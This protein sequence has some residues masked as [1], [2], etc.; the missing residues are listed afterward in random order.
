MRRLH[1]TSIVI[2]SGS[3]LAAGMTLGAQDRYALRSP[4]GISFAELKGYEQWQL[5]APSHADHGTGCGTSPD[6]GCMKVILGNPTMI[7]AY[8]DGVPANGK[9]VPDGAMFAK[10]EWAKVRNADAGYDMTVPGDLAEVGFMVKD[11]TRFVNTDGWGY[12]TFK[13]ETSSDTWKS[14]GDGPEFV[15]ACHACHTIVKQRDFVFTHYPKR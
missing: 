9:P 8:A 10:I 14:F 2:A 3:I 15:D 5:I 11:S 4:S 12:A 13:Y 7:K 6:P 1:I